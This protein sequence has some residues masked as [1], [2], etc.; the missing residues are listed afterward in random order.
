LLSNVGMEHG[1]DP[2]WANVGSYTPQHCSG[3]SRGK[4]RRRAE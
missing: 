2:R 4:C 1:A 3:T